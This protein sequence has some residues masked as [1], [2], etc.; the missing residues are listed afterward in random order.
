MAVDEI[1]SRAVAAYVSREPHG[2]PHLD[3]EVLT[4]EFGDAASSLRPRVDALV[5]EMM[6]LPFQG[7]D[8]MAGTRAAESI[9]IE[10]HPE[11]AADAIAALG[12][13][14]SYSWR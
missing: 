9:M 10:R 3:P 5:A 14:Y 11:L 13:F 8:L 4:S 6:V 12:Y 7:E 2:Y 1:L